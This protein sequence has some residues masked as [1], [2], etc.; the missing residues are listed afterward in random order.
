MFWSRIAGLY[1]FFMEIYNKKVYFN[2]GK[3][4]AECLSLNTGR[5]RG[6]IYGTCSK[7]EGNWPLWSAATTEYFIYRGNTECMKRSFPRK[8]LK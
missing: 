1:D 3:T 7:Q 5:E 4:V 6:S 8:S 2:I